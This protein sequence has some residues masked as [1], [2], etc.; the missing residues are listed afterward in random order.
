MH[1]IESRKRGGQVAPQTVE[2]T[3]RLPL[4]GYGLLTLT[5]QNRNHIQQEAGYNLSIFLT[6]GIYGLIFLNGRA[7][8]TFGRT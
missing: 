8:Q 1:A 6:H 5:M 4:E 2:Y 3:R 7:Q